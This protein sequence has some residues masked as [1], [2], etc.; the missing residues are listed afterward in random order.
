[1]V[2]GNDDFSGVYKLKSLEGKNRYVKGENEMFLV[3]GEEGK[4]NFY[5]EDPMQVVEMLAYR[6]K[7]EF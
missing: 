7:R 4:W 5:Y 2:S 6:P 3:R 1:M